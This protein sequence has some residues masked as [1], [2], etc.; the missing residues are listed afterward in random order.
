MFSSTTAANKAKGDEEA[1]TVAQASAQLA[2]M[3]Q[4]KDNQYNARMAIYDWL[5]RLVM[6]KKSNFQVRSLV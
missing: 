5:D 1:N 3:Q 2:A 4:R 6:D